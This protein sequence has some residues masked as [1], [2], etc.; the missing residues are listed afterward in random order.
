MGI[1]K[2][3]RNNWKKT[4]FFS[5]ASVY[6]GSWAK[7]KWEDEELRREFCHAANSFGQEV[8]QEV[9]I[10][11]VFFSYPSMDYQLIHISFPF[12]ASF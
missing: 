3:L 12:S 9:V 11:S 10:A 5:L 1:V 2:T 8:N 7:R 4:V 6:G